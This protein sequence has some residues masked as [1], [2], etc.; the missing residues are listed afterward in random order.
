VQLRNRAMRGAAQ[1][2]ARGC[3]APAPHRRR[4]PV[5]PLSCRRT[6]RLVLAGQAQRR[7]SAPESG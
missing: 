3:C 7:G 4:R 6:Q 2:G 1:G 5:V